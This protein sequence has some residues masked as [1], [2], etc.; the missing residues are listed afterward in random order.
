[1]ALSSALVLAEAYQTAL[2]SILSGKISSYTVGDSTFTRHN[3]SDLEK[4]YQFWRRQAVKE[5]NGASGGVLH[6]QVN[7]IDIDPPDVVQTVDE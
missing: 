2:I 6:A 7:N 5:A 3:I 4:A 1:M